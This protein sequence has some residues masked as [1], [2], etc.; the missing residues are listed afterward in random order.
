M[1]SIEKIQPLCWGAVLYNL[2]F[3]V[4]MVDFEL[5]QACDERTICPD[6][7]EIFTKF[8]NVAVQHG[9]APPQWLAD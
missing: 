5:M 6:I 4:T 8:R 9:L 2:Q 3:E 1:F 7:P